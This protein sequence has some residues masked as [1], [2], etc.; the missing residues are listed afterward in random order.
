MLFVIR[1]TSCSTKAFSSIRPFNENEC[2]QTIDVEFVKVQ[3]VG[4]LFGAS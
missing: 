4:K 2:L 1:A 3:L